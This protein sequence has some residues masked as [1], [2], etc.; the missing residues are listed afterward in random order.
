MIVGLG[1]GWVDT[2][3]FAALLQRHDERLSERVFRP[4]ERGYARAR[5]RGRAHSLAVRLAA[6]L[7]GRDAL[8]AGRIP[9]HEIEVVR[10]R[11]RAPRLVFHGRAADAARRL[12]VV[13][14]ALSLT[15]DDV[16]CVGQVVL[17]GSS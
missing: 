16:A 9:L 14:V 11:G 8:G 5:G 3:R 7:A 13:A 1:V 2:S 10:E 15:H 17:E 6:K 12:G 4:G